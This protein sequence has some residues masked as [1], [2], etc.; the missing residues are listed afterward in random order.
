MPQGSSRTSPVNSTPRLQRLERRPRVGR[1]EH[2]PGDAAGRHLVEPGHERDRRL[3]ALRRKL[4]PPHPLS[5]GP[6]E[7]LLEAEHVDV[8]R[9]RA[10]DVGDG[11]ETSRRWVMCS[12]MAI[13][14]LPREGDP[15][16]AILCP[17][18]LRDAA[19]GPDDRREPRSGGGPLG[20]SRGARLLS[21][22]LRHT[23]AELGEG[24]DRLA[25]ALLA[26]GIEPG[27]RLGI[28]SP[29]CAEWVSCSTR[30]PRPGSPGQHQPGVSH[31]GARVR[32]AP[33]GL[34]LADRRAGLQ[35]LRLRRDDRV[36]AR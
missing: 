29:N 31:V 25:R 8:E 21:P 12:A 28:W 30:P 4:H 3:R 9:L 27:D 24:V 5:E 10:I 23:Y 34:P 17:R 15:S 32:A 35:D 36:G 11:I 6:V 26:G 20:R 7:A 14:S 18:R 1:V 13:R 22:D 16:A 2:E 19:A 33:V